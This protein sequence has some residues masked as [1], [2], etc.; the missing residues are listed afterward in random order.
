[1]SELRRLF[2]ASGFVLDAF[3]QSYDLT[4]D[5]RSFIFLNPA[6]PADGAESQVVEVENWFADV[7]ARLQQ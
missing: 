2:D 1:V 7:Q 3:H 5:G 4:P 6:Q